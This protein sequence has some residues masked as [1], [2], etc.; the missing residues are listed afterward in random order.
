MNENQTYTHGQIRWN[1]F[2]GWKGG[3]GEPMHVQKL[4]V[5]YDTDRMYKKIMK[6]NLKWLRLSKNL[7]MKLPVAQVYIVH[8]CN[9]SAK[10]GTKVH[11]H[12]QSYKARL[13]IQY[14]SL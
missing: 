5:G 2:I 7:T 8:V 12:I 6:N 11:C 9:I 14:H 1:P 13:N 10:S 4:F 3:H